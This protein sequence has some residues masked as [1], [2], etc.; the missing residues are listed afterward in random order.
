MI[1]S[2]AIQHLGEHIPET[3]SGIPLFAERD[4]MGLKKLL[5]VDDLSLDENVLC[6]VLYINQELTGKLSSMGLP[7]YDYK[8]NLTLVQGDQ[9]HLTL[10]E[11]AEIICC[12]SS[13][14]E[15]S[16]SH[17]TSMMMAQSVSAN[18]EGKHVKSTQH[19]SIS[20]YPIDR[21]SATERGFSAYQHIRKDMGG[22]GI[23]QASVVIAPLINHE[24][25]D[26]LTK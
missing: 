11:I 7:V 5:Y 16:L 23:V 8:E 2:V 19:S 15:I 1:A 6:K 9:Y 24:A 26:F 12:N 25:F 3:Y 20:D 21:M 4:I 13:S 10:R 17:D 22:R 14:I 18:R